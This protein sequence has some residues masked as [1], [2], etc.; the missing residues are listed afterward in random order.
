MRE[1]LVYFKKKAVGTLHQKMRKAIKVKN[2]KEIN[3]VYK[4]YK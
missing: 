1:Y 3:I 2:N 4:Y